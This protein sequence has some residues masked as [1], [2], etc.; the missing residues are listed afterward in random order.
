MP[1]IGEGE[2]AGWVVL[3]NELHGVS[4]SIKVAQIANDIGNFHQSVEKGRHS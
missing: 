1:I 2:S 4:F 3:E